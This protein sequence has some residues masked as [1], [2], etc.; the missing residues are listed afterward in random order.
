[1]SNIEEELTPQSN[2]INELHLFKEMQDTDNDFKILFDKNNKD[3]YIVLLHYRIPY[4]EEIIKSE[5]NLYGIIYNKVEEENIYLKMD[6]DDVESKYFKDS[7]TI[8]ITDTINFIQTSLN[9]KSIKFKNDTND[10][11]LKITNELKKKF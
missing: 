11:R 3:L 6:L 1:M 10:F 4:L 2:F 8:Y 7:S 9:I 5:D